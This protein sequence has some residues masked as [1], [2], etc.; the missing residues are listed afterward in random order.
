MATKYT[1]LAEIEINGEMHR[2]MR[3]S[4]REYTHAVIVCWGDGS[5]PGGVY[6]FCG[7]AALAAKQ[8]VK[9]EAILAAKYPSGWV[10]TVPVRK[11]I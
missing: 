1:Y 5:S 9:V 8:Q 11:V 10:K 4:A 2:A 3:K 7:S 6:G